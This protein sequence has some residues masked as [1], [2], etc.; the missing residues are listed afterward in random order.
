MNVLNSNP[1]VQPT[2]QHKGLWYRLTNFK[3]KELIY[4][5]CGSIFI[6]FWFYIAAFIVIGKHPTRGDQIARICL[7]YP[8]VILEVASHFVVASKVQE[9]EWNFKA[10]PVHERRSVIF[11]IILGAGLDRM[12]DNFHFMVANLSF[13]THRILTIICAGL[14]IIFLFTLHFTNASNPLSETSCTH[15]HNKVYLR[16]RRVLVSFILNFAYLCALVVTL[17]GMVG[18]LKIGVSVDLCTHGQINV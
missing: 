14:T 11:T 7:W 16:R 9:V 3:Q 17:Q 10:V 6:S 15:A 1:N 4:Y 18:I 12:T 8:P 2:G 13:N 5:H